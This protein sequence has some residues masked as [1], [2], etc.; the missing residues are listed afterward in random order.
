MSATLDVT[1]LPPGERRSDAVHDRLR[2]AILRGELAPGDPVPSERVLAESLGVNRQAVREALNR[3]QQA[4][5]LLATQP[6]D[7]TGVSH[8][9]GYDSPSQFSREYRRQFGAPPSRDA[10]RLREAAFTPMP[11]LP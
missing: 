11:S 8:R 9:V 10:I 7:V 1:P 6:H 2:R 4:R 3:L 5:L